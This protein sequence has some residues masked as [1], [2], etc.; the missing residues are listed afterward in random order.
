MLFAGQKQMEFD[1][2]KIKAAGY[3]TATAVLLT[4][5]DDY[6]DFKALNTGATELQEK[7][8]TIEKIGM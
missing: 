8:F 6:P 1:I 5:S 7:I 3:S 4:N 2:P